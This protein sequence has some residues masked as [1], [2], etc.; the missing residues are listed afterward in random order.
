[1]QNVTIKY[2]KGGEMLEVLYRNCVRCGRYCKCEMHHT[3]TRSRGGRREVPLCRMCHVWVSTHIS[4]A[5]KLGLYEE[6]YEIN[7][8]KDAL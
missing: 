1:M 4:E 3:R 7:R 2:Y 6:G 8:K 5:K